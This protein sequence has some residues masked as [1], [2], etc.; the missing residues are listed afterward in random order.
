MKSWFG[1][2]KIDPS[3][4]LCGGEGTTDK[5]LFICSFV[6]FFFKYMY[7][8]NIMLGAQWRK[9]IALITIGWQSEF[10]DVFC[11]NQLLVD[12]PD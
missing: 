1:E 2:P 6:V 10:H 8:T 4:T 11:G 5:Y 7:N 3:T 9:T 12:L